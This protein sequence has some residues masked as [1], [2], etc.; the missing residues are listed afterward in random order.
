V[1][2][3]KSVEPSQVMLAANA[4]SKA[5]VHL[6]ISH[7]VPSLYRSKVTVIAKRI[8]TNITQSKL[9]REVSFYFTVVG[10]DTSLANYDS[11]APTCTRSQ[12]N[13]CQFSKLCPDRGTDNCDLSSWVSTFHVSD[14]GSGLGY[15]VM[16]WPGG[17]QWS[18]GQRFILGTTAP[19]TVH[20]RTSCCHPGFSMKAKDLAGNSVLCEVG[21]V[22]NTST[23]LDVGILGMFILVLISLVLTDRAEYDTVCYV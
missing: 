6:T 11:L 7:Y 9:R 17:A 15:P 19:Q 10:V 23:R 2:L 22:L 18:S 4:S 3:V 14:G 16:V 13:K 1:E 12:T 21:E 8:F 5:L 20:V